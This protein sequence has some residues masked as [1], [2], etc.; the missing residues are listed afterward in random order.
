MYTYSVCST[1]MFIQNVTSAAGQYHRFDNTIFALANNCFI[2][3]IYILCII[4]TFS[5]TADDILFAYSKI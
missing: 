3:L 2:N 1:S 5:T 4:S